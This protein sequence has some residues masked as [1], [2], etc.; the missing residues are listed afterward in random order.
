ML[1]GSHDIRFAQPER[2]PIRISAD[3]TEAAARR[4][5]QRAIPRLGLPPG[6]SSDGSVHLRNGDTI[7]KEQYEAAQEKLKNNPL[8]GGPPTVPR[9]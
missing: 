3:P 9:L 1:P 7:S 4:A 5:V 2:D 6:T 8:M